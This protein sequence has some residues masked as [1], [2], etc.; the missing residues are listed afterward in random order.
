VVNRYLNTIT[1]TGGLTADAL[2]G[3][4]I[5]DATNGTSATTAASSKALGLVSAATLPLAGGSLSGTLFNSSQ[6]SF[7][8]RQAAGASGVAV[9]L[10]ELYPSRGFVVQ[11]NP[12]NGI[13]TPVA[14][15]YMISISPVWTGTIGKINLVGIN[16]G[17]LTTPINLTNLGYWSGVLDIGANVTLSIS[18]NGAGGTIY[19]SGY[20]I[21]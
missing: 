13:L 9:V 21:G 18:G 17:T 20:L 16:Y 14:G 11:S 4:C 7:S 8:T 10:T 6:P 2:K 15:R 12:G 5:S 1:L 19:F 3:T